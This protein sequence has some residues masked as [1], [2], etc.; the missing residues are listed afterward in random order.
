MLQIVGRAE[1]SSESLTV[2]QSASK[3][4]LLDGELLA[5]DVSR[6]LCG[7]LHGA[8]YTIVGGFLR[9]RMR[10]RENQG[11]TTVPL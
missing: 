2:K 3:L 4:T 5:E 8:V 6:S 10:E 7:P 1:V 9:D 11:E